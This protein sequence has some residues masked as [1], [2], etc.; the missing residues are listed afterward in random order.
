VISG[1]LSNPCPACGGVVNI[2]V[3]VPKGSILVDCRYCNGSGSVFAGI[4]SNPCP[5]C[6]GFG[7]NLVDVP[8]T[9]NLIN[10]KYCN[11]SGSVISGIISSP[12]SVCHGT[13]FVTPKRL[14]LKGNLN[15]STQ[16]SNKTPQ[17]FMCYGEPDKAFA[18][19]LYNALKNENILTWMYDVDYTPGKRTWKEIIDNRRIS[20][21]FLVICS[22]AS[23]SKEGVLKEIEQQIDENPNKIVPI[24]I[25]L[26]WTAPSFGVK[27]GGSDLKPL[28]LERNYADFVTR[29]FG[30]AF[31]KLVKAIR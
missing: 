18:M 20:R 19:R 16:P 4:F 14:N 9:S 21:K 29:T 17:C 2:E 11:G 6:K 24:S 13:G 31:N 23:L 1:I 26:R 30:E 27:R 8:S 25:D 12:C 15:P 28:L 5:V 22:I 3:D 10:C 7:K